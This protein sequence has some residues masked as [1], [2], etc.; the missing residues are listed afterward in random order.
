MDVVDVL[1]QL[2][3]R[4]LIPKAVADELVH[5]RTPSKVRDWM[6]R[7]VEWLDVVIAPGNVGPR[8]LAIRSRRE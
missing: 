7:K 3:G 6:A 5:P 2:Y 8:R 1:P 4:V